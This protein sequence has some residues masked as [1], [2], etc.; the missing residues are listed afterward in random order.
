MDAIE[1]TKAINRQFLP[2]SKLDP[3]LEN[4]NVM[5][6]QEFNMLAS[7][8]E[9]TGMT[10]PILVRPM[11]NDR[12]RIVGGHHRLEVAK[13]IGFEEVPVTIMTDPDFDD[14]KER[15]Q[16]VRMNVI[17][18][19]ISPDKFLKLYQALSSKYADE[20][21]AESFGFAEEEEFRKLVK[22]VQVSLPKELQQEFK[23]ASSE[24]KTIDDLSKLL[25]RLFTTYGETLPYGYMLLDFGGK[26][27]IW[28]RLSN[29]TRK[30]VLEIG[31]LCVKEKRSVDSIIGGMI[32]LM[33]DGKL[34]SQ[35]LQLIAESKPVVIP[36]GVTMPTEETLPV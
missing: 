6:D 9:E 13:V 28:L 2:I 10:D 16:L 22:Q 19:R 23:E 32:R 7:N 18:G 34:S 30:A 21:M 3:N 29:D 14:D 17:R 5:T 36:E 24:I 8:I 26:D 33:A 27:S 12:Y 11:P 35:L 25:N 20:V 15:F 4:P 31:S 1:K